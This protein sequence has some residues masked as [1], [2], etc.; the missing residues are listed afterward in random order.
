MEI[1]IYKSIII[2][3]S[4]IAA[5]VAFKGFFC[6]LRMLEKYNAIFNKKT[7]LKEANI[8]AQHIK[9][10]QNK[11]IN[12]QI[13]LLQE[14]LYEHLE[15]TKQEIEA[16]QE[17][18]EEKKLSLDQEYKKIT[19]FE[20]SFDSKKLD[21]LEKSKITDQNLLRIIDKHQYFGDMVMWFS[22]LL[23]FIWFL[24]HLKKNDNQVLKIFLIFI[25]IAIVIQAGFLGGELVHKYHIYSK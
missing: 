11:S 23:L 10:M 3:L 24:L 16:Q 13:S 15:T 12:E 21:L 18:I 25:L 19:D 20:N 1:L 17:Q 6:V 22:I 4:I 9:K 8:Q 14:D 5:F 7:L 2:T